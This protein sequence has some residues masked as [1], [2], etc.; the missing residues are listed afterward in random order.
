MPL[1]AI[2]FDFDGLIL[3]TETPEVQAWRH[4]F[5]RHGLDFPDSYW[6]HAI[7]RGAEQIAESPIDILERQI[8]PSIDRSGVEVEYEHVRMSAIDTADPLPGVRELVT[9]SRQEGIPLAVASSSKHSWVDN[10]LDRLGL[11]NSFQAILCADD[12]VSAKPFPDLYLAACSRLGVDPKH[13]VALEDSTNGIQAAIDAGLFCVAVPNEITAFMDLSQAHIRLDT[14]ATTSPC[15][16]RAWLA[17]HLEGQNSHMP[18]STGSI[19]AK[20]EEIVAE[21]KARGIWNIPKPSPEDF[22]DMGAFGMNTMAFEQW[23]RY[24]LCDRIEDGLRADGPWPSQS[25]VGIHAVREFDGRDEYSHL[26][27]LLCE[28]DALF[29]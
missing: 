6:K 17:S 10:H 12:V 24:V 22:Q 25:M 11:Y 5:F 21:M 4:I 23:L 2:I 8:G 16:L 27:T 19:R 15:D 14:L 13:S 20:Y 3:D 7:G 29:G 18:S 26:A 9:A 1:Q 28:F